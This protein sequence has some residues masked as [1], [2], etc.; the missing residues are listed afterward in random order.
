VKHI[1]SFPQYLGSG[2]S[3]E[4]IELLA[5]DANDVPKIA[6][7]SKDGADDIVEFGEVR[8]I[9]NREKPDDHGA[10]LTENCS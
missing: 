2:L 3:A 1:P 7:P 4:A 9:R 10:H 6:I 8:V 5:V